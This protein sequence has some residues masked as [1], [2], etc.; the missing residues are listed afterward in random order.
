M[1]SC[2][3]RRPAA[4]RPGPRDS[5]GAAML[6][7]AIALPVVLML[8]FAAIEFGFV[9][10]RHVVIHSTAA[11][12][13]RIVAICPPTDMTCQP[14][15]AEVQVRA[16]ELLTFAV[17]DPAEFAITVTEAGGMIRVRVALNRP[18]RMVVPFLPEVAGF[19]F[20]AESRMR[21]EG[22]LPP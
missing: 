18:Y 14:G 6:E 13:A 5:R 15:A 9:L 2:S 1:R 12:V 3:T 19:A 16:R 8:T 4:R 21:K 7:T 11:E 22:P 17:M 20:H 10:Y